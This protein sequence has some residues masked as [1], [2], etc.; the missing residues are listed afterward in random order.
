[1]KIE[2]AIEELKKNAGKRKFVQS[3]DVIFLLQNIDVRKPDQRI[4]LEVV[5]PYSP[6]KQ[7]HSVAVIAKASTNLGKISHQ[8]GLDVLEPIYLEGIA[9]DKK[10]VKHLSN[11]FDAFLC[12]VADVRTMARV[13]GSFLGPKNKMPLMVS[14]ADPNISSQIDKINRIVRLS[15][16][17]Q[18]QLQTLFGN[19]KMDSAKIVENFNAIM[20]AVLVK[21]PKG[22]IQVRKVIIKS[23]MAAPLTVE[24]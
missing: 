18:M 1:M 9:Q 8:Q 3:F 11:K 22:K 4:K 12:D 13:L 16:G 2:Q 21:L 5:L 14:G 7:A 15:T 19:E 17:M 6:F 20:N 23:T 10:K 24:V